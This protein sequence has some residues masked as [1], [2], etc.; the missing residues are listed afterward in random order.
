MKC[1]MYLFHNKKFR[2]SKIA[3][4]IYI[5]NKILTQIDLVSFFQEVFE[6]IPSLKECHGIWS[7]VIKRFAIFRL[8]INKEK[9]K[10]QKRAFGSKSMAMRAIVR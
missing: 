4:E 8:R 5:H 10:I 7:K 6:R 9:N 2:L 3:K 1:V